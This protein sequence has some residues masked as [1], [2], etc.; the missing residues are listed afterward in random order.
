MYACMSVSLYVSMIVCMF[1]AQIELNRFIFRNLCHWDLFAL[2][3]LA[4]WSN[5]KAR[6]YVLNTQLVVF[7]N[8]VV[9]HY[10]FS[11]SLSASPI[12]LLFHLRWLAGSLAQSLSLL[13][14]TFF[15][16]FR[17]EWLV[18]F[19]LFICL[20]TMRFHFR[21]KRPE[22]EASQKNRHIE[23]DLYFFNLNRMSNNFTTTTTI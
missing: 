8:H 19:V 14:L 13:S 6:F 16:Y 2:Y 10:H 1:C 22:D 12:L 21:K 23:F 20:D 11:L 5:L 4:F 15:R 18:S 9:L 17:L 3:C 7:K